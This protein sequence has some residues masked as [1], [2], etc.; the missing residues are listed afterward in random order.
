M[1]DGKRQWCEAE[2]AIDRLVC[3]VRAGDLDALRELVG[4]GFDLN[5]CD[6]LGETILERVIG[7]LEFCPGKQRYAVIREMLRL[8][9]NPGVVGSDG[10][11]PL[12]T[13]VVNMDTRM[14]GILLDAG[15]DPNASL[16]ILRGTGSEADTAGSR[17]VAESLYDWAKFAYRY[18][19]WE[20]RL[21]EDARTADQSDEDAWLGQVD[22]LAVEYG[23]RRP[24]HLRLLRERGAQSTLELCR[25][26]RALD[27]DDHPDPGG[28]A[29]RALW[30]SGRS[31]PK[32]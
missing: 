20:T 17:A 25:A 24:D 22:R 15:A 8:G 11:T 21:P 3:C 9:A 19:V 18:E 2:K 13:A 28:H 32:R 7:E 12:F 29:V 5:G 30:P 6:Q 26:A 4:S 10:S 27:D 16:R 23:K 14:I 31:S 1:K